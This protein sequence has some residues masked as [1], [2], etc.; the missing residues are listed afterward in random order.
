VWPYLRHQTRST[1]E[2]HVIKAITE[3][4]CESLRVI[5]LSERDEVSVSE[6]KGFEEIDS[7]IEEPN[8]CVSCQAVIPALA[9][10]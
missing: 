8:S 3:D 1:D 2:L 6:Y 10:N 5:K 7:S 4:Y 9:L